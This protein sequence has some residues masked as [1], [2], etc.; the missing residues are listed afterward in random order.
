M[1]KGRTQN[2]DSETQFLR[3]LQEALSQLDKSFY[4]RT[5]LMLKPTTRLGVF[6]VE[7]DTWV[8]VDGRPL[9][10]LH[11]S[12]GQFPNSSAKTLAAYLFSMAHDH[13]LRVEEAVRRASD[14]IQDLFSGP[15]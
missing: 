5:R 2:S 11:K 10:R 9:Q 14:E 15:V 13:T 1:S 7:M 8:A 12:D 6:Q 3:S 4:T